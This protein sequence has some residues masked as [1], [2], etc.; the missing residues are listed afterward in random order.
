MISRKPFIEKL[1]INILKY[2]D[3]NPQKAFTAKELTRAFHINDNI[4][5]TA[6]TYLRKDGV[7]NY[8]VINYRM[9]YWSKGKNK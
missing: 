5:Y 8:Q 3:S 1:S 6:L 9:Y 4:C 7:I 2:V